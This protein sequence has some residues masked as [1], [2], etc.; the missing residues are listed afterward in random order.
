MRRNLTLLLGAG[1]AAGLGVVAGAAQADW[2]GHRGHGWG[3]HGMGPGV[4]GYLLERYDTN[5]DGKISQEEIDKN[6]TEWQARFDTD[7]DGSLSLKEFEALWLEARR[8]EMVREFQ[9]FDKDG[10]AKVT[11]EEYKGPLSHLVERR[12]RNG[13]GFLSNDDRR[14]G[15]GRWRHGGGDQDGDDGEGGSQDQQQ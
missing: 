7:K 14:K 12:D 4:G 11:L 3:M 5:K 6:R 13:D 9:F 15:Q 1:I 10:D 8:Q 2:G